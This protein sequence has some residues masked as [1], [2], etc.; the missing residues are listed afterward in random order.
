MYHIRSRVVPVFLGFFLCYLILFQAAAGGEEGAAS[1]NGD[2]VFQEDLGKL[3]QLVEESLA[4][5]LE[6][7]DMYREFETKIARGLPL[8]H[9][10]IELIHTGAEY[11]LAMREK[12]MVYSHKYKEYVAGNHFLRY[13]PGKGTRETKSEDLYFGHLVKHTIDPSDAEGRL[14]LN[15]I[16]LSLAAALVLY[17]NYLVAIYPYQENSKLRNLINFDNIGAARKLDMVTLNYLS[18]D[19]REM[20]RKAIKIFDE[21]LRWQNRQPGEVDAANA[22]LNILIPGSLS[23][24]DILHG[25]ALST[26]IKLGGNLSRIFQDSVNQFGKESLNVVSG[27]FGNTVGLIET[28]KGKLKKMSRQ[29]LQDLENQLEPLDILLEKTPF[30]L[31]DKFIPGHYGHV[32]VWVGGPEDW[33]KA[34]INILDQE[35]VKEN[36][37]KIAKGRK[38]VEAL[39]PGVQLNT[40]AH[41]MN[42]DDFVVLRHTGLRRPEKEEY[43]VRAFE[44]VG[45]KYDFNFDVE[46]D[47]KIVC[48]E[49]AYVIFHDVEWEIEQSV[50]RFTISPDN[51][52]RMALDD[53]PLDVVQ[54]YHDGRHIKKKRDE[55]FAKLLAGN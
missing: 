44:Q 2:K 9:D 46:T 15:R 47:R 22:Y 5:R 18:I 52:A 40:L 34:G 39:R 48:S 12:I 33:Q 41:F 11:Y 51:V 32:A 7:R 37:A 28:R 24:E 3:Q 21:D 25:H 23:Y 6:A 1:L 8:Y 30:R 45:K 36:L 42:I 35:V 55:Y 20:V 54:L 29:E 13:S 27:L 10:D 4:W 43:L 53:G 31:T 38:V 50:G 14:I 19:N 16:K 49:L 26:T 17:D